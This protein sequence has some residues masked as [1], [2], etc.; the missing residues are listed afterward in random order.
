MVKGDASPTGAF[1]W[2]VDSDGKGHNIPLQGNVLGK[3][4]AS[5]GEYDDEG[6]LKITGDITVE[7]E[8]SFPTGADKLL[9]DKTISDLVSAGKLKIS[10]EAGEYFIGAVGGNSI[11]VSAIA[12]NTAEAYAGTSDVPVCVGSKLTFTDAMRKNDGTGVLQSLDIIDTDNKKAPL[13]LLIFNQDIT[14]TYTNKS[15]PILSAN[16]KLNLIRA[17]PINTSD[18]MTVGG[19]AI[20]D[21]SPGGRMLTSVGQKNLYG[22]LLTN[23]SVSYLSINAVTAKLGI[24]RD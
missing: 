16:D 8:I 23:A 14:G 15:A 11:Q 1:I 2:Y 21:I 24:M 9:L 5:V 17:I 7:N 6:N 20:A 18:Y 3:L 19:I 4:L 12:S 13:I 10:N 22:V